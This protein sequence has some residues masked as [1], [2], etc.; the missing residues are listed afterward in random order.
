MGR[1]GERD[2]LQI[3]ICQERTKDMIRY[4]IVLIFGECLKCLRRINISSINLL[5]FE[6]IETLIS[7]AYTFY[8]ALMLHF[9]QPLMSN[10]LITCFKTGFPFLKLLYLILTHGVT[11]D[12][13][14]SEILS[15]LCTPPSIWI[16]YLCIL[17]GL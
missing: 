2:S 10:I 7:P 11:V 6:N 17:H 14:R 5:Y 15:L 8:F 4:K 9:S 16:H 13:L 3:C 12:Q 1:K